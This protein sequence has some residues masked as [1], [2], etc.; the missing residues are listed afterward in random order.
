M[1]SRHWNPPEWAESAGDIPDWVQPHATG[2]FH[3]ADLRGMLEPNMTTCAT[4]PVVGSFSAIPK[5]LVLPA[6]AVQGLQLFRG[7]GSSTHPCHGLF[8]GGR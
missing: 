5:G 4:P 8:E 7:A 6:G 2:S 1:P 3:C